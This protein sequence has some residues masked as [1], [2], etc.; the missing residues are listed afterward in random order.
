MRWHKAVLLA[1]PFFIAAALN[2]LMVASDHYHWRTAAVARYSFLFG[3]P[4]ARVLGEIPMPNP[5]SHALQVIL[6]YGIVLWIPAALYSLCLWI[7]YRSVHSWIRLFQADKKS[8]NT[9]D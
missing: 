5:E 6:G 8:D 3:V 9:S 7:L 2:V 4:W 1:C